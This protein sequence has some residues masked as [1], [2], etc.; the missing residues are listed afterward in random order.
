[1]P[2]DPRIMPDKP[3]EEGVRLL[4]LVREMGATV[5]EFRHGLALA[6]PGAVSE[7]PDRLRVEH[8]GAMLEIRLEVLPPRV[9]AAIRLPRLYVRLDFLSGTRNQ[10]AALLARMDLAM[11]RGGG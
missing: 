2:D 5:A 8:G 3:N 10:Q 9:I 4:S 1:M 11:Q 6:F 7:L